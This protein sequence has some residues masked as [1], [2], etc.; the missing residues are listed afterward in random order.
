MQPNILQFQREGVTQELY[1]EIKELVNFTR[2]EAKKS[3]LIIDETPDRVCKDDDGC[4]SEL[5]VLKRDWRKYR[6]ALTDI[7]TFYD[8]GESDFSGNTPTSIAKEALEI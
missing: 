8:D 5:A 2:T 6:K 4:P 7:A 3:R 1:D